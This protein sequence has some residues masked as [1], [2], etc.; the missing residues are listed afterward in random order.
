MLTHIAETLTG[1]GCLLTL[2]LFPLWGIYSCVRLSREASDKWWLVTPTTFALLVILSLPLA[3]VADFV[4]ASDEVLL[5]VCVAVPGV[6]FWLQMRP[7]LHSDRPWFR[8]V[9]PIGCMMAA[10]T[11]ILALAFATFAPW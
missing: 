7:I 8:K 11:L 4:R 10:L 9:L 6:A 2:P 3:V 5:L 1:V